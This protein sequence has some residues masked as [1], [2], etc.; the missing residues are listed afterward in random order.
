M[1]LGGDC[2]LG[3]F[4]NTV[5]CTLGTECQIYSHSVASLP[6]TAPAS[7][8]SLSARL[9]QIPFASIFPLFVC[10]TKHFS[11]LFL[12][13]LSCHCNLV[14]QMQ[15]TM[16]KIYLLTVALTS[17]IIVTIAQNVGIGTTTPI[18]KLHV[19]A[20][21]NV[22]ATAIIRGVNTGTSGNAVL[23][24]SNNAGTNAVQGTSNNGIGVL[25]YSNGGTAVYGTT[26]SGVSLYGNSVTGYALQAVGK[27]KISGGN[28]NPR[29]GAT[30]TSD[31]DGD[32]VWKTPRIA[33]SVK[34]IPASYRAIPNT[35]AFRI[36]FETEEYD[37]G[38]KFV[39]A[40]DD[41][42][43]YN[44]SQFTAPVAG[45]YVFDLN[46]EMEDYS[47]GSKNDDSKYGSISLWRVSNGVATELASAGENYGASGDFPWINTAWSIHK[48]VR[49]QA[50][51]KVH[52]Q[53]WVRDDDSDEKLYISVVA[54]ENW[55]SGRLIWED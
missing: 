25:G 45:L 14:F 33:F 54:N 6:V 10:K 22:S 5:V 21:A 37:Y 17:L 28:T 52:A 16:K 2:I 18:G 38:N 49:L 46:I 32:A 15:N 30:L 9:H 8:R 50:G 36:Q 34:G 24:V 31:V 44:T 47:F 55:F 20:A 23:G 7:Q 19:E 53:V 48:E 1:G 42:S 41:P 40:G 4:F 13:T 35:T 12:Q 51:D 29:E 43:P 39:K 27:V 26:I 11:F 3:G